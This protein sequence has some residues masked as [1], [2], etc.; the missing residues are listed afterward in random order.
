VAAHTLGRTGIDV[1]AISLGCVEIG[2]SYGPP[3]EARRELDESAVARLLNGALDRGV[4]LLDT[5]PAYGRSEELIGRSVAHRRAEYTLATKVEIAPDLPAPAIAGIVASSVDRSL[6]RLHTDAVDLLL[7]HS[8]DTE[9]LRAGEAITALAAQRERGTCSWIGATTYGGEAADAALAD[10]RIDVVQVAY[11]ALDR[12]LEPEIARSAGSG[13]GVVVRSVFLKGVLTDRARLLPH[14]LSPL[15]DASTLLAA[16][17]ERAGMSLP[18]LAVRFVLSNPGVPTMLVG[19]A[20]LHELEESIEW[21]ERG[22]LPVDMCDEIRTISSSDESLLDPF[23][24][25]A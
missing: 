4:T 1:G 15:R 6:A 13:V 11:S 3:G 24:W 22:A 21:A 23:R 19:T 7:L 9:L 2:M 25:P 5:A 10:D 14:A 12:R 16:V 20:E 18:E 17:A 8:A